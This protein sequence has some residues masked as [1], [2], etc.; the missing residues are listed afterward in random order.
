MILLVSCSL[1]DCQG[2]ELRQQSFHLVPPWHW[3]SFPLTEAHLSWVS[4]GL[5][6]HFHTVWCICFWSVCCWELQPWG[7]QPFTHGDL[8]RT[9]FSQ[10]LTGFRPTSHTGGWNHTVN[11][12]M[13]KKKIFQKILEQNNNEQR[14][15]WDK[16]IYENTSKILSFFLL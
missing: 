1:H 4:M 6:L 7:A 3:S 14:K 8:N 10:C 15:L 16:H 11:K 2:V 12:I 5:C 9:S 13:K